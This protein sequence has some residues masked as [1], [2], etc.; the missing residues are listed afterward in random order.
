MSERQDSREQRSRESK[1][2]G[3]EWCVHLTKSRGRGKAGGF[4]EPPPTPEL[5]F[6]NAFCTS[7]GSPG[8]EEALYSVYTAGE[9]PSCP[10]AAPAAGPAGGHLAL[11]PGDVD[12]VE[13]HG[14]NR[15][16]RVGPV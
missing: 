6:L 13:K 9:R 11:P 16:F 14:P 5:W 15:N 8:A 10:G 4:G 1:T 7:L 12:G 3:T 2:A